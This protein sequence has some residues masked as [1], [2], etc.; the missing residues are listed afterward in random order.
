MPRIIEEV[1]VK[2]GA[3]TRGLDKGLK[4]SKKQVGALSSAFKKLGVIMIGVFGA[5]ALFTGFKRTLAASDQ[6]I[7]VA[8]GVGFTVSEY[9]RLTF[10][11]D[12]VGVS[13]GSA[14]IALG[15]FQKRLS[16]AVAGVSPQFQ[17]A[18]EQAG[19]D[20]KALSAMSPAAAFSAAMIQ[21]AKLRNDPRIA[22]L[23]GN[24]FE[25]QSGKDILQVLRQWEKYTDAR[26]KFARRVGVLSQDQ[27]N[28]IEALSEELKI[29]GAQ[30]DMIK[31]RV[32]GDA[33]PQ[34]LTALTKLEQSGAFEKM[35]SDMA[36]VITKF[37]E[38]TAAWAG[39]QEASQKRA[40][41]SASELVNRLAHGGQTPFEKSQRANY[42]QRFKN[43]FPS[44]GPGRTTSATTI[45]NYV[46]MV[47]NGVKD[48][49]VPDKAKQAV[50]DATLRSGQ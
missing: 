29:Y 12:Q 7:K 8:K 48:K 19:L 21:L 2:I 47:F 40:E 3:D 16:K 4:K 13:A 22:G 14:K 35:A 31:M 39:W 28:N 45:N 11:L 20:T 9:Q 43:A 23:T 42:E 41:A 36:L 38:L 5:R 18:F 46:D 1:A 10:A 49:N 33:A 27:Q 24:V 6:L 25:E 26:E 34:L 50:T 17:K 44:A 32:V 30:W 37:A 15:D